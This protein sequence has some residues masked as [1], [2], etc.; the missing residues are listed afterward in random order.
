MALN[1][2]RDTISHGTAGVKTHTCG[3]QPVKARLTA[4]IAP[5]SASTIIY[6]AEGTTNGTNQDATTFT[7]EASRNFQ[8]TYTDRMISISEWNGAAWVETFKVTFDSFTA[9]EFKYNV[10][11]ANSAFQ[12]RREVEG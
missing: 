7:S 1:Y 3:F 8:Q 4:R 5:G 10:V 9:T 12:L 2:A 6:N 11:T